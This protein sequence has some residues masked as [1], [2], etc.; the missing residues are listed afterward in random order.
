MKTDGHR[1]LGAA[2]GTPA[3]CQACTEGKVAQW[4]QE[5]QTLATFAMT[6]PQAAYAAFTHGQR[7]KWSL[8]ARTVPGTA[9]SLSPLET[10]ISEHLLPAL[11]G[12]MAP[13]QQERSILAL[14]CRHGGLGLIVPAS[15]SP[16]SA[17]S[18]SITKALVERILL[19]QHSMEGISGLTKQAK[20][21]LDL[22]LG[23]ER[24]KKYLPSLLTAMLPTAVPW[25]SPLRKEHPVGLRADHYSDTASHC[26][27]VTSVMRLPCVTAGLPQGC[28]PR[29]HAARDSTYRMP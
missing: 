27:R 16:Q 7:H 20:S 6:Q 14:P 2:L 8:L 28:R 3:F 24:K 29:A 15:L 17:N 22:Q 11:T 21:L 19:Q 10:C 5:V 13:G 9:D 23:S 1:H 18:M 12:R 26:T 25:S 4:C